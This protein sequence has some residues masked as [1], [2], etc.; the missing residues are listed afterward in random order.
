MNLHTKQ[1]GNKWF[2][3]QTIHGYDHSFAGNTIE[4]CQALMKTLLVKLNFQL[5]NCYFYPP[6]YK[7]EPE[8][9]PKPQ[10][11]YQKNRLDNL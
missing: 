11:V 5:G 9:L 6:V 8:V 2:C 4:E 1:I 3:Y 10:I 7:E